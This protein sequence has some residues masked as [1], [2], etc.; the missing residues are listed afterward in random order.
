M[1]NNFYFLRQTSLQQMLSPFWL[2]LGV[3]V[4]SSTLLSSSKAYSQTPAFSNTEITSYAQALLTMEPA[5][6]KAFA[7]VR[8]IMG[9]NSRRDVPRIVCNDPNSINA[10]PNQARD[11]AIDYCK[12]SQ[13]IV[14]D[15]GLSI[16]RFN[17]ITTEIKNNTNLKQQIYNI[18]LRLQET[19]ESH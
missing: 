1:Q 11:I 19:P 4:I 9:S 15:N 2:L 10:L 8:E 16:D 12:Y 17:T 3:G 18:L 7:K 6:R 5:R 13:K 14:E